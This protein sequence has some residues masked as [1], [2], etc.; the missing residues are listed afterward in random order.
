[1]G[2]VYLINLKL[3]LYLVDE[4]NKRISVHNIRESFNS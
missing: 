1:M 4:I 2:L 3:A